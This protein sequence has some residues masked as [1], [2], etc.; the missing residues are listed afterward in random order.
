[1]HRISLF[2]ALLAI[3]LSAQIP[4]AFPADP[5]PLRADP[6]T[7]GQLVAGYRAELIAPLG[8]SLIN[9]V[10][11]VRGPGDDLFLTEVAG[12]GCAPVTSTPLYR[13][14]MSGRSPVFGSTL[15]PFTSGTMQGHELAYDPITNAVYATGICSQSA[16]VYR[17]NSFGVIA[18]LNASQPLDD[19]DGIAVGVPSF[20]SDPHAFVPTQDGL[21][22]IN[23]ITLAMHEITVDLS[24]TTASSLGNWGFPVFDPNTRTL[25]GGLVGRPAVRACVEI[26]FTSATTAVAV[27]IGPDG[28]KPQCL[29]HQGIRYF[30]Q[31]AQF[32]FINPGTSVFVPTLGGFAT[33]GRLVGEVDGSFLFLDYGNGNLYRLL[34]PLTSDAYVVS[35][36]AGSRVSLTLEAPPGR[37]NEPYLVLASYTGS[38]PGTTYGPIIVPLNRD[39]I[40]QVGYVLA[41]AGDLMTDQWL[42]MLDSNGRAT[43]RFRFPPG[44]GPSGGTFNLAFILGLPEFSSNSVWIHV[45]P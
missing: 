12:S 8:A 32:G 15:A 23:L 18:P 5:G 31:F 21:F 28:A 27:E 40:T 25:L 30:A 38:S 36:S 16:Y 20:S 2:V 26:T 22:A 44:L 3:G 9:P 33:S 24:A 10:S 37:A 43:A 41:Q 35:T 1:M 45:V 29:D 17:V 11:V 7:A 14:P 13:L 42:G 34:R 4:S 39:L 19:P 6:V